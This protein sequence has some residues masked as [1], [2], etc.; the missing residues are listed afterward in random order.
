[1]EW[2]TCD[3]QSEFASGLLVGSEFASI[4][5]S[6]GGEEFY[7][8]VVNKLNR[9]QPVRQLRCT[10]TSNRIVYKFV[11]L[12]QYSLYQ[13]Q[14]SL[15]QY[16]HCISISKYIY[17]LVVQTLSIHNEHSVYIYM[18][19]CVCV[20]VCMYVCVRACVCVCVCVLYIHILL[21]VYIYS[22]HGLCFDFKE[23]SLYRGFAFCGN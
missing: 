10:K 16:I 2:R 23:T 18:C 8:L 4:Y 17:E 11:S 5:F 19:V 1:M 3:A 20:C 21:R 12:Y 13:Y 22:L 14:Y 15:Y 7:G 6:A 9:L